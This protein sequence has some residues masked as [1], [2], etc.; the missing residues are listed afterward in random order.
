LRP[1]P[2]TRTTI[3]AYS[4]KLSPAEHF[5]NWQQDPFGNFQ[6]RL[7]FNEPAQV[8]E[9]D[10][11]LVVDLI[12]LNPFD[13]FLEDE[14]LP[15]RYEPSLLRDL[16]PYFDVAPMEARLAS[17]VAMCRSKYALD[18]RRTM[19]V[20]VDINQ[21]IQRL[22]RYDIR[23]EP[24][25]FAPEQTLTL[26]HG[27]CRDFAWLQCQLLRHLGFA[28]RFASGYSIQL[29]PDEKPVTGAAGVLEDV[30]DL[31]AWTEVFLPGAG[32]VGLDATSGLLAGEGHIPLACTPDPGSAAPVTGSFAWSK[33][34]DDDELGESFSFSMTVARLAEA[35]RSTKPYSDEVWSRIDSLGDVV[36]EA[37]VAR[38]VRLSMGGEPTFVYAADAD[39]PEWNNAALGGAKFRLA[40]T[41]ARR[42]CARFAPGGVIQHGQGKWYPG[43]PLPR[44]AVACYFRTD[45]VPIWEDPRLLIPEDAPRPGHGE[46]QA[47]TFITELAGRLRVGTAHLRPGYEDAWYYMWRERKLPINVD[48]LDARLD[49]ELERKR[50]ARI[51]ESGLTAPVGYALPLAR[52]PD[53]GW[54]SGPWFLRRE[55]LFL[56]PGD[57]PM[58]FRLPLDSLPWVAPGDREVIHDPDPLVERPAL[59]SRI[60]LQVAPATDSLRPGPAPALGES[61]SMLLRT[62]LCVEPRQG[63]LHV[64]LPPLQTLSAY[65]ELVSAVESTAAALALPVRLE[66][67]PP[68]ADSRLVKF[69]LTPD[70][71]VLEVNIQPSY[72]WSGTRD[73]TLAIYEE[74]RQVGLST[75]KFD[76]DGRHSGTGGGNHITLGGRTPADSPLLRRPDLLRSLLAYWNNHPSLSYLFSGL[77]IGPTSQAPRV[78]EARQDALAE[79]EIAF[80][81]VEPGKACAP[82]LVDRL[83]RH[84]LID[85]TG[86][87]HRAEFCIDKL[88]SP[89]VAS[90][91]Q[92]IL[93]LRNFEMPPHAR[94]SLAQQLLVR[95][96]VAM[97]WQ[98]PY[99]DRLVRWGTALHD[100]FM[101]PHFVREDF[102]DVIADL[103]HA[104]FAFEADWFRPHFEFRF[105]FIG[106][107]QV[108]S[109]DVELRRALEPW[110]VL[111]EQGAQGSTA[112]YVD[113]S[114][115]RLQVRARNL[116]GGRHV[117]LCNGR[118]MPLAPTGTPG[119]FVAGVR[120]RAWQPPEALHP[121]IPVHAPLVFDVYDE[122]SGRAVGGCTYYVS[123]PGGLS[124][125]SRP[126]N[127][128]VAESRRASRFLPFG[129]TPGTMV[130][131]N[132][133]RNPL[134]PMTLDL[135]R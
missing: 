113:S 126:Y 30:A 92:G 16:L 55:H 57:S 21:H 7:V 119:E 107:I 52:D 80:R 121:T 4:L 32:W 95:A 34:H 120:F 60:A 114:L 43:E 122:W 135:R 100:R 5:L 130:A 37:L 102:E 38:D 11:D 42:L 22:L 86:N 71:G 45:Q 65:L 58:G 1:A 109:L 68:L 39:A 105:P 18:G 89:E 110:H 129:H 74:A 50:L 117:L 29:R 40:D 132:E 82:W 112:R 125:D 9:I 13:F 111:G 41:L 23:M 24:G 98:A 79:L 78:D 28:T 127:A 49:D 124:F 116:V 91:R 36:D 131:E 128:L 70:P 62:T 44:W 69:E 77:F 81:L 101:L 53:L 104:G 67:Y 84:L 25:V 6:A 3:E 115:E 123:H 15:L 12:T 48:P 56:L 31:H 26:G 17:L 118:R 75:E 14:H 63:I 54:R 90:G 51:F 19:D 20:L 35:P 72:S 10:V 97:M 96:V 94:M 64:F 106:A 59:P 93:E 88:Y 134:F 33:K 108:A 76:L 2:H 133:E 73:V 46:A 66:G 47:K 61:A 103:V 85:V 99:R 8:M 27:S 87:T 83:F